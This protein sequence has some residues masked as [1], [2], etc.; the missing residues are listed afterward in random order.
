MAVFSLT[1]ATVLAGTAWTGTAPG[2]AVAASGTITSSVDISGFITSFD[3]SIEAEELE[4]TNFA[5]A[6]WRQKIS[7]LQM[8][9]VQLTFNDDYAATTTD[10]YFGLGGTFGIGVAPIYFD[11]KPTS[12]ARGSTNPSY[13]M[14]VLNLGGTI[15]T[16]SVGDVATKTYS[17]PTTGVITRLTS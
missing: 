3:L 4:T 6:G 11:V 1:S 8:G 9:T 10:P 16:G 2:A 12:S 14:R 7:G 15:M 5:A 17:F 13:V